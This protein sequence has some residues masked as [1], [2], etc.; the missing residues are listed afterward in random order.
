MGQKVMKLSNQNCLF[1]KS[2][3]TLA[4]L[5]ATNYAYADEEEIAQLTTNESSASVGMAAAT[6]DNKSRSIFGQYNGLRKNE[7]NLLLDFNVINL[8]KSTGLW[9]IFEGRNLGQDNRD[10][11]VTMNKQ[12]N[13]K[14]SE[15]YSELTHREIRTVNTGLQGAG[16]TAPTVKTLPAPGTG[17]DINLELNRK[18]ITLNGE[19]WI[20]SNLLFE[21]SFKNE[22]K[23]GSR[24]SGEGLICS[25]IG[26]PSRYSCGGTGTVSG[27]M[28][29]LPEPV[30]T[31]TKQ[32]DAK[33]NYSGS[34][35]L[36][37]AGYYGSFFTSANGSL[38]PSLSGPLVNLN[39]VQFTSPPT[40]ASY[41]TAPLALPPENQAH[42]F[43]L[44]GNYAFSSRTHSTFKYS[45]NHATQNQN[46][47]GMG[48]IGG[49]AGV[50]NL[51]AVVDTNL[52]QFG[53][54]AHP[55]KQ[56]ALLG[57]VRYEDKND[58]TPLAGYNT[59]LSGTQYSN[60]Y[61]SSSKKVNAKL[62]A[63]YNLPGNYSAT[64]GVDYA[65]VQRATPP[66][67]TAV[68]VSGDLG[69]SL[70]GL[71]E[72]TQEQGYR[73][74]LRRAMSETLNGTVAVIHSQRN[75]D[76]WTLY[77]SGGNL[78][79]TMLDRQRDKVKVSAEWMPT[80]KISL[81]FNLEQGKDSYTGPIA[82]GARDTQMNAYAIDGAWSLSEKLKFTGY[83]NQ[84]TQ[85][86]H[87]SHVS[88]LA[89]L[90]D[91]NH[92]YGL[93]VNYKPSSKIDM[94]GNLSK[95]SDTNRYQVGGIPDVAYRATNLKVFGKY[96]LQKNTDVRLDAVHQRVK[97]KEWSWGYNGR[98]FAYSDNSTVSLQPE[99]NVTAIAASYIY[100]FR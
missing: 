40:L 84:S 32:I 86:Q 25:N 16:T 44:S 48:L 95:V 27:A 62:E 63:K 43:Y 36:V 68:E 35:F 18:A 98:P 88:Y 6:G 11:N 10:L 12:G 7:T 89:E 65:T 94:G 21:T 49:P 38:D 46:F 9:T 26:F 64:I 75:G 14:L 61:S 77:S 55:L 92:S 82:S 52:A 59:T 100:K 57:N 39:A 87:I 56:L 90:N 41:L 24:L 54:T 76:S 31:T 13:W 33:L 28:L 72:K 80:G 19:K 53:L 73:A 4:V 42:Q 29:M 8:Q 5:L 3:L 45:R 17:A 83:I 70:A 34:K 93:G 67:I 47:S 69:P 58:K 96:A 60:D 2:I 85:T 74:E 20:T 97:L 66:A 37:S 71:R 22:D 99:Q 15:S 1:R 81:Q 78:P 51:G 30:K 79:L 50:S 91:I 23:S